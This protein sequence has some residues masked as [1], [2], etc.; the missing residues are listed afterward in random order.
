MNRPLGKRQ[1]SRL[2]AHL[3]RGLTK[4]DQPLM[5][6]CFD[7]VMPNS[8]EMAIEPD[9]REIVLEG[10]SGAEAVYQVHRSFKDSALSAISTDLMSDQIKALE[11]LHD[12]LTIGQGMRAARAAGKLCWLGGKAEYLAF[13]G[14]F[15]ETAVSDAQSR[16]NGGLE[17][18]KTQKAEIGSRD[19]ILTGLIIQAVGA[20]GTRNG[21][22][23][24]WLARWMLEHW[25]TDGLSASELRAGVRVIRE[26]VRARRKTHPAD[27]WIPAGPIPEQEGQVASAGA[28]R[29]GS[30]RSNHHE[31]RHPSIAA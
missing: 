21:W 28:A 12:A 5:Q 1:K 26:W 30:I 20:G 27:F 3:S 14:Q 23:S 9:L 31:S 25:P 13:L 15:A 2:E 7:H 19:D 10:L 18:A 24:S 22:N 16:S 29:C 8:L 17:H 11:Q 4:R 6:A